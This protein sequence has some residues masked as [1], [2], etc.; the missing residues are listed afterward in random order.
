MR[1]G[2][3]STLNTNSTISSN[4]LAKQGAKYRNTQLKLSISPELT[5]L[6][7]NPVGNNKFKKNKK[8]GKTMKNKQEF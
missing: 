7:A 1:P 4:F 6:K 8:G 3:E 5:N 2:F